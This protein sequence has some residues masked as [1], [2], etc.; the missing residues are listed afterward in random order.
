MIPTAFVAF[1]CL[2]SRPLIAA[3]FVGFGIRVEQCHEDHTVSNA[4]LGIDVTL[5]PGDDKGVTEWTPDKVGAFVF[6]CTIHP[7]THGKFTV[8]VEA[9]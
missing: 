1:G 4:D 8:A 6:D 3:N 9:A 5:I 7:G 2:P